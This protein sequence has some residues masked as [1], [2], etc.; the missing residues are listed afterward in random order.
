MLTRTRS[1]LGPAVVLGL[2]LGVAG[3]GSE[4]KKAGDGETVSPSPTSTT[5]G[6][7]SYLEVPESVVLTEPGT[8]LALGEEGVIAFLLRQ[9]E[10]AALAVTVDRIERTSFRKSF[11]GW[12]VDDATAARTPH[13]VRVKVTNVGEVDLGGL[14]LDD[15]IWAYDGT[16]L[17]A[18]VYYDAK[19]LPACAGGPLPEPFAAGAT[20]ALCQ[21]YFIAPDH[22]LEAVA[23]HPPAK[24]EAITWTGALSKVQPPAKKPKKPRKKQ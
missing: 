17:E 18:P 23:F 19:Q 4:E 2:A 13:F 6:P 20:A 7:A 22:K 8:D 10:T 16:T 9:E 11:A 21:V 15:V 14:L 5:T 3:C 1:T 24:L 12:N